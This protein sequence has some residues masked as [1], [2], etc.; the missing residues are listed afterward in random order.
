MSSLPSSSEAD[1]S[2]SVAPLM[3]VGQR[4]SHWWSG[5][6]GA[7]AARAA[8]TRRS[9]EGKVKAVI[10]EH[11]KVVEELVPYDGEPVAEGFATPSKT[12]GL[13]KNRRDQFDRCL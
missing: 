3:Q 4:C 1:G 6:R 11:K 10:D 8:R 2:E 5:R 13:G 7:E 12:C 9:R